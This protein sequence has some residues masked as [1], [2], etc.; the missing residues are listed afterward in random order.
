VGKGVVPT[1]NLLAAAEKVEMITELGL[2]R[3][4]RK[5]SKLLA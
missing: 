1:K 3:M 2:S 5:L 4:L